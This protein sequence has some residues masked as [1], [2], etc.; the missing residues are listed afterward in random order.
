MPDR[1]LINVFNIDAALAVGRAN[2]IFAAH[3]L[4]V[5]VMVTPNSTDQMR[6]LGKGSWQIVSTA[7][8]NVLGWSG[9]EGAEIIAIAQ[10][11]AG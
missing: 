4:E 10:V 9:R 6:G 11:S 5:E 1:F 2:G 8:D 7:F 3:G